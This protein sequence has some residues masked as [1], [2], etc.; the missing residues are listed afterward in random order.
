VENFLS[1][2]AVIS[3]LRR[4]LSIHL[5]LCSHFVGPW[6]GDQPVARPLH[7]HTINAHRH[8]SL[9]WD[10]ETTIPTLERAKAVHAL[11]RAATVI[12]SYEGYC[13]MELVGF[14][15]QTSLM[16][17]LYLCSN[18]IHILIFVCKLYIDGCHL[19]FVVYFSVSSLHFPLI[20]HI[21]QC[22]LQN[23]FPQFRL[24]YS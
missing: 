17:V 15:L 1:C 6:R 7:T 10:F 13:S 11:D 23:P 22:R 21:S 18:G 5:W 14:D 16:R 4:I 3:V 9:E 12:G 2:W 20:A 19:R 24:S 8:P